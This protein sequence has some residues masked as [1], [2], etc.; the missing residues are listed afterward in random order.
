MLGISR[1]ALHVG[2]LGGVIQLWLWLLCVLSSSCLWLHIVRCAIWLFYMVHLNCGFIAWFNIACVVS[3]GF[4]G[5]LHIVCVCAWCH[6]VWSRHIVCVVA[7]GYA[8]WF[9]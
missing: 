7:Y 8:T 1:W 9:K 6:I 2:N 4:A 3:C 5:W